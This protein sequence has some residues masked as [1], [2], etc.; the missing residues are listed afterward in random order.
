MARR[1]LI[2]AHKAIDKSQYQPASLDLRLG[3]EVYRVRAS[4]LPGPPPHGEGASRE[5]QSRAHGA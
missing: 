3:K 4:F 1:R 2:Q 5:P